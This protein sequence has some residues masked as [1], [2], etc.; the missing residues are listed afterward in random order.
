MLNLGSLLSVLFLEQLAACIKRKN[1]E[2]HFIISGQC[3]LSDSA[4]PASMHPDHGR[5]HPAMGTLS[6]LQEEF[7]IATVTAAF[8]YNYLLEL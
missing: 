8:A 2:Q 5:W 7:L 1:L 6:Q 3:Q 4:W